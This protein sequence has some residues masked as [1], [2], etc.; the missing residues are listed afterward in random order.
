MI[1]YFV[2]MGMLIRV[3]NQAD[4]AQVPDNIPRCGH[5]TS[6]KVSDQQEE[7]T[8]LTTTPKGSSD[9]IFKLKTA[10]ISLILECIIISALLST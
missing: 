9:S 6:N 1:D 4:I 3:G 10:L 8:P 2:G 5:W 7:D